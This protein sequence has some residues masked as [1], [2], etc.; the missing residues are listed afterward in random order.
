MHLP[1]FREGDN[2]E[3]FDTVAEAGEGEFLISNHLAR[4]PLQGQRELC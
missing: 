1:G 2:F 3:S 4:F